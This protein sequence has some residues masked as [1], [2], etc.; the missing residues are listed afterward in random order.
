[1][2]SQTDQEVKLDTPA[3]NFTQSI[4]LGN[5]RLGAMDYGNPKQERI[6]I[7]V[8]SMWS[9]GVENPNRNDASQYLPEI[10]RLLKKEKTRTH[11]NYS[12]FVF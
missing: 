7:N 8:I 9:G 12:G 10:Q 1:M 3:T 11:R 2:Y 6:V 5:G 4:P